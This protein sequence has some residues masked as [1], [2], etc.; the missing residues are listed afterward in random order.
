MI[1]NLV[2]KSLVGNHTYSLLEK[3]TGYQLAETEAA[4]KDQGQV[5]ANKCASLDYEFMNE[6]YQ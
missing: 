1:Y 3:N 4:V 5:V 6:R 2:R